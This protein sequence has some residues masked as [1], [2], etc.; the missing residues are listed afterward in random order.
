MTDSM[1]IDE[2]MRMMKQ[3]PD[4]IIVIIIYFYPS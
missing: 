2:T 3:Y 4:F 1:T